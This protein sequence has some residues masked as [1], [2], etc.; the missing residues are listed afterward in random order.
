MTCPPGTG[1]LGQAACKPFSAPPPIPAFSTPSWGLGVQGK[2]A[3]HP[4]PRESH[5]S[6]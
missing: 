3:P 2:L 5:F 1:K 6:L 4:K